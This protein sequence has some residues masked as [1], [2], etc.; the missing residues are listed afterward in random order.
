MVV[1]K[2]MAP[3][4][5]TRDMRDNGADNGK[6]VIFVLG[7]LT[8]FI[9]QSE[10]CFAD[11]LH[12]VSGPSYWRW[13]HSCDRKVAPRRAECQR[14]SIDGFAEAKALLLVLVLAGLLRQIEA[15]GV[16]PDEGCVFSSE[17][18]SL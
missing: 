16:I 10:V 5:V 8:F 18:N 11:S 12:H 9:H 15:F 6:R 7:H 4:C 17:W 14:S 13:I 1:W 2:N 3:R